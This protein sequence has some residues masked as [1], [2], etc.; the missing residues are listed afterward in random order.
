MKKKL[1]TLTLEQLTTLLQ[2]SMDNIDI[3]DLCDSRFSLQQL[4]LL[5]YERKNG[6]NVSKITNP[7]I[8]Y[9]NME[10]LIEAIKSGVNVSEL[11]NPLLDE[12]KL[13]ILIE[14]SIAGINISGLAN[15]FISLDTL[16]TL[17]DL[18]VTGKDTH[19][20]NIIGYT[21]AE[22]EEAIYLLK[23]GNNMDR[24]IEIYRDNTIN[25]LLD[26]MNKKGKDIVKQSTPSRVK[27][28][29]IYNQNKNTKKTK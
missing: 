1:Q 21:A 19:C 26:Y 6:V 2:A 29:K 22:V 20:I 13:S 23:N 3:T 5:I 8:P 15:P 18:R 25:K 12:E 4:D 24:I 11:T 7:L 14:A 27:I 16:N 28:Y 9:N 17:L 10:L